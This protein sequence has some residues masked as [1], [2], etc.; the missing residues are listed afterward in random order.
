MCVRFH[1]QCPKRFTN[2]L[3]VTHVNSGNFRFQAQYRFLYE[4]AIAYVGSN[5]NYL[6][7][8]EQHMLAHWKWMDGGIC[9]QSKDIY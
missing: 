5:E 9:E 8:N 4:L 2:V 7:L 6:I 1:Q 3:S